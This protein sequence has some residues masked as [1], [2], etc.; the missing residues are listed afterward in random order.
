LE[1][2]TLFN[3]DAASRGKRADLGAGLSLEIITGKRPRAVLYRAGARIKEVDL[4]NR[5]EKRLLVVEAVDLGAKQSRLASALQMSRQTIHNHLETRKHF[6]LE[7][8]IHSYTPRESKGL[9]KQREMHSEERAGG[10][11]VKLLAEMR[12]ANRRETPRQ[13]RL[14][15]S[16]GDS[17]RQVEK[18]E[19]PYAETHEWEPSRYAGV[20]MYL[21][22][23]LSQWKW[24]QLVMGHFGSAYKIFMVFLLMAARNIRSIEQLKH[25]RSREAGAVLG[26]RRLP[27]R[28][29]IWEWFY[30]AAELKLSLVLLGDYFR[31]QL[32]SG[33]VGLWLW[34]TDGHLL[35][36][37]GKEP[38][39]YGYNTQRQMPIPGQTNMVTCDLSGRVVDFAIQ[40]GKGD[41]RRHVLTVAGKWSEEIGGRPV[42][43]FDREGYG[44]AFFSALV[45]EGTP[46]VTWEK[47]A[48][49]AK[50]EA[51]EAGRFTDE[52]EFNGKRYG[53]F[54][55]AKAYSHEIE[56]APAHSFELRRIFLWNKTGNRR[57]C[58]LAWD[59]GKG[60]S[61]VECACA[62]LHRWGASENS[63]KHIQERH[64]FHYRPGFKLVES[65]HQEI[66]NPAIKEKRDLIQRVK[67][68]LGKLYKKLAQAREVFNKD[69]SPRV[70]SVHAR[71]KKSIAEQEATLQRLQ[72]EK[73]QLPEKIDPT[74]L[75]DYRAIKRIDN[76]GKNLFDFVTCSV[77]NARKQMVEW[78]QPY[79]N[80]DNEVVDLFY[81]ITSCHGWV[82]STEQ[83]VVVRLEPLQQ[84]KR[85]RAQEQLCR[86]L[87]SL[88]VQ[89]PT[90]KYMVIEVGDSPL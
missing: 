12:K 10:N 11:K 62:I 2:T 20:F 41:L 44:A 84:E 77:W 46:F 71:V 18:S 79:F 69:G 25:V 26:L 64:P 7:G 90:G 83:E 43:V 67:T 87:T 24:L 30:S 33:L 27:S 56:D 29:K 51:L 9:R 40:E 3:M 14:N 53:V 34:F 36:Y 39:R 17:A 59:G 55:E 74:S 72:D 35:P 38:V 8:L 65:E 4:A 81:A 58:G 76:E 6:G 57:A 21:P 5:V 60:M 75:Q 50:L 45:R 52:F 66:A 89:T 73:K 49:A 82:K 28:P 86:K 23:L 16:F 85:R 1:Q 54:E 48:D 80:Q 61:T 32:R 22:P 47:H 31:H 19:Q 37:T 68:A 78:L 88:A 42:M 63:F 15:F 70:S 13:M